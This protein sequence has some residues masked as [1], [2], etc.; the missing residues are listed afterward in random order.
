MSTLTSHLALG[1][2]DSEL[3][4]LSWWGV[5]Y[6][7]RFLPSPTLAAN[8]MVPAML[9]KGQAVWARED[10]SEWV[11]GW[12]PM[13]HEPWRLDLGTRG[14]N[15]CRAALRMCVRDRVCPGRCVP[16]RTLAPGCHVTSKSSFEGQSSFICGHQSQGAGL[17]LVPLSCRGWRPACP[18]L[19]PESWGHSGSSEAHGSS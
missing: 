6:R 15:F 3:L 19:R 9:S 4:Q 1:A 16:V 12:T 14:P 11:D 7:C 10:Q 18:F 13:P 2:R 8:P 5:T 17:S